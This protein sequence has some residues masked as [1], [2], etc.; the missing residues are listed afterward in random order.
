MGHLV[1]GSDKGDPIG[2]AFRAFLLKEA[3]E[4]IGMQNRH[5]TGIV[6]TS[7]QNLV[8]SFGNVSFTMDGGSGLMHSAVQT[9]I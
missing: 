5:R 6:Q 8:A 4:E 1:H 7:A 2:F 9:N 3:L